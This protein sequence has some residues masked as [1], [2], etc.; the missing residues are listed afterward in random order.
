MNVKYHPVQVS[1]VRGNL[2]LVPDTRFTRAWY[3]G[4]R[5]PRP[6]YN[7]HH[8]DGVAIMD[9]GHDYHP[10]GPNAVQFSYS[11]PKPYWVLLQ[12][13]EPRSSMAICPSCGASTPESSFCIYCGESLN[14]RQARREAA[15]KFKRVHASRLSLTSPIFN[16]REI[17]K[18][19]LLLEDHLLH[20]YKHCPDCIRKH[21]LTIEA[22]AEEAAS[23]DVE[24]HYRATSVQMAEVARLW[25]EQVTDGADLPA[26]AQE[27]RKIRKALV[28]Q[29]HDPRGKTARW[30]GTVWQ[31]RQQHHH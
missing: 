6:P 13:G 25:M 9:V 1:A 14:S 21:L 15:Q 27:V 22:F 2:T 3:Y 29:V 4:R 30:V 7:P 23:L 10:Q 17:A 12:W 11:D 16:F 31:H 26:L 24:G 19:M 28:A 8:G 20:T 18:Q 5:K